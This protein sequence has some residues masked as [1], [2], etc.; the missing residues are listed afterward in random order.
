MDRLRLLMDR[1]T[2]A[3]LT[4]QEAL[5]LV[6]AAD[7]MDSLSEPKEHDPMMKQLNL[8]ILSRAANVHVTTKVRR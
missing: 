3:D 8:H 7:E 2:P 4:S 1:V 6:A 5:A